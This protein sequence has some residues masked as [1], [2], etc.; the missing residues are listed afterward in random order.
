MSATTNDVRRAL[1]AATPSGTPGLQYI[2]VDRSATIFDA[3]EGVADVASRRPM[4]AATTMMAYS[5]S[6]TITAATVLQLVERGRLRLDEPIAR[7]IDWQPYGSR[8]TIRHLLSHTSGIPNPIPL[9]WVHPAAAHS[10]F[11]ERATLQSVLAKHPRLAFTPGT[12]FAYSNIGYWLCGA[13]VEQATGERFTSYV[14][15]QVLEPL[16]IGSGDLA[17]TIADPAMHASGYLE[18]YSWMNLFKPLLIDRELIGAYAGP[19]LEIRDHYLNGPA[20]GG[21]V[22][23]AAAFGRF[24]QDQ[25]RDHS[26]LFGDATKAMFCEQQRTTKG[27]IP[28]TLGWHIGATGGVRFFYKE[29]GGGGFHCMMRLYPEQG[30]GTVVMAN[31]TGFD[32]GALLDATDAEFL[33]R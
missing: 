19:W 3:Q 4:L 18:K 27:R 6:K 2:V 24:L 31:A 12:R 28:M 16:G 30:I 25:L 23:N 22:G 8:I 32:V 15:R 20:F 21:L 29:G 13:I 9:R 14:T 11:D 10:S 33:F 26:R 7:Y 17:Y 1:Q 5:M